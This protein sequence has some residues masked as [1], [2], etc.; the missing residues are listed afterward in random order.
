MTPDQ[1]LQELQQ[2]EA[3]APGQFDPRSA[4]HFINK[5]ISEET[6]RAYRKTVADF[7]QLLGE[8]IPQKLCQMMCSSGATTCGQPVSARLRFP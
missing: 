6:R 2:R 5:S 3:V 1:K 8:G 4:T 7:F